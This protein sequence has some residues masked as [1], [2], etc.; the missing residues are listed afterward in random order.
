MVGE[1]GYRNKSGN[2]RFGSSIF[3]EPVPQKLYLARRQRVS[4]KNPSNRT[5]QMFSKSL[6]K[7]HFI[8]LQYLQ[9]M[10]RLFQTRYLTDIAHSEDTKDKVILAG[11]TKISLNSILSF[12]EI[13]A[14]CFLSQSTFRRRKCSNVAHGVWRILSTT[15]KTTNR[16]QTTWSRALPALIQKPIK[17]NFSS[18]KK[19]I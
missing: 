5:S 8:F 10:P 12:L 1:E 14:S 15:S 17:P 13:R 4:I 19:K 6:F 3:W 2:W 7:N 11:I 16:N 18:K 9:R